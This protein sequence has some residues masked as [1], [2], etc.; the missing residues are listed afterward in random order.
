VRGFSRTVTPYYDDG[1]S[2]IYHADCLDVLPTLTDVGLVL[3]SPPYNLSGDGNKPG[4]PLSNGRSTEVD[5]SNG[6]G[7]HDDA[8][9]HAEYVP[10]QQ[11]VLRA[12]WATLADDG[13]IFYNH[14]P[15][16]RG[17]HVRLPLELIP[18]DIPLRQIVTWNRMSGFNRRLT[19]FVPSYEWIMLLTKPAF[20]ITTYT[21]FDLWHIQPEANT[22]HPAPFPLRLARTAIG[23]TSAQLVL[24]PFMGSG[25]TLRAAKDCGR[26]AIGI[27][28]DERFCEMA[29]K[30]LSQ[31]VLDLWA[32]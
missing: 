13:A 14:K 12:C 5:L 10:W 25:T 32:G 26:K 8:M 6:Y 28:I 18:E 23:A 29:A 3:T 22:D 9:P 27:E 15:I 21:V 20:R 7:V 17:N 2:T 11:A 30:R 31:E 24:D 16:V 19:Y 4:H 1:Q